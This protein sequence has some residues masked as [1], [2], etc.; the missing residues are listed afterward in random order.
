MPK[1]RSLLQA[2][3][4]ELFCQFKASEERAKA[5]ADELKLSR[6]FTRG[7]AHAQMLNTFLN[8]VKFAQEQEPKPKS[9]RN[10]KQFQRLGSLPSMQ[11]FLKVVYPGKTM[12]LNDAVKFFQ[13]V[14]AFKDRR[15]RLMHPRNV[16][17]LQD[18]A[19]RFAKMLADHNNRGDVLE[20]KE[21]L[22]L[23][24]FSKIDELCAACVGNL[25]ALKTFGN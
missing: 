16:A 8:V 19:H 7:V 5:F 15:D 6:E 13:A 1:K 2:Q 17:D 12:S 21:K 22:F 25:Q 14:D 18:D 20:P 3:V 10:S 4:D 23:D 9:R 24:V 11:L